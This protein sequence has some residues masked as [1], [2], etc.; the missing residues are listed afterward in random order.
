[1]PRTETCACSTRAGR[2]TRLE[3]VLHH[4]SNDAGVRHVAAAVEEELADEG[5]EKAHV[6]GHDPDRSRK[7]RGRATWVAD[8]LILAAA[9]VACHS[10]TEHDPAALQPWEGEEQK[11]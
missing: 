11:R 7:L 3:E 4:C 10:C 1:M 6:P 2:G 5:C 9:I 8:G